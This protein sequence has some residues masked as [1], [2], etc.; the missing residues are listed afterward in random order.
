LYNSNGTTTVG[1]S[2]SLSGANGSISSISRSLTIGQVYW[3]KVTPSNSLNGGYR[4]TFNTSSTAPAIGG[5]ITAG[6]WA[7]G[8]IIY[9]SN[10][11]QWFVFTATAATQYIHFSFGTL[12]SIYVNV[13]DSDGNNLGQTNLTN[14]TK[15]TSR[16]LTIG[17][18]YR[19]RVMNGGNFGG[20]YKIT[21]NA[22]ATPPAQ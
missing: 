13:Y 6:A 9:S 3:I 22:S 12:N 16:N 18:V 21:I 7:D 10:G 11:V 5:T 2:A 14:T 19:M 4:I 15:N 1:D 17:D 20:T 8:N